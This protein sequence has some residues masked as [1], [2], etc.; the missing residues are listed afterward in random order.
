MQ[1]KHIIN[2]S[3]HVAQRQKRTQIWDHIISSISYYQLHFSVTFHHSVQVAAI[4]L[5]CFSHL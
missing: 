5:D 1:I 2:T 4:V 3:A